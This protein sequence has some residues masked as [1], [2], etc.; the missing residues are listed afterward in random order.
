MGY[1]LTA[2]WTKDSNHHSPDVLSGTHSEDTIAEHDAQLNPEVTISEIR[3]LSSTDGN[4]PTRLQDLCNKAAQ[5]SQYQQL[6]SIILNGFP[7]HHHQLPETCKQFWAIK[8]HLSIDDVL[9]VYGCW[10]L[11]PKT[12]RPQVISDL[13]EAHQGIVR[14]KQWACLTVYC[15]GIDN[16]IE[17]IITACQLCQDHLPSNPKEPIVSK[18]KPL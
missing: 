5:D 14:T 6:H 10:L 17:N 7:A 18:P 2:Q 16:D 4:I 13:H 1:N 9:I 8:E 11:I 15:P 12:M 3:A